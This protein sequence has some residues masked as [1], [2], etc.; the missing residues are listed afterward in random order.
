MKKILLL[1]AVLLGAATASQAGVRFSFGIPFPAPPVIVAPPP[2]V[3]VQPPVETYVEPPPVCAEP[4]V[5]V[6]PPV[7]NFRFGYSHP[8]YRSY[9]YRPYYHRDYHRDWDDHH[10]D[11]DDHRGH[12]Y[13]GGNRDHYRR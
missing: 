7:L 12:D 11:W 13:H 2:P 10:H 5:V 8:Y 1:S 4:P 6:A 3:Y 9:P